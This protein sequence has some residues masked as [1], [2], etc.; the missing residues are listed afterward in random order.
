MTAQRRS[1]GIGVALVALLVSRAVTGV[2]TAALAPLV[3]VGVRANQVASTSTVLSHLAAFGV[4]ALVVNTLVA[5]WI[6]QAMVRM[7]GAGLSF[8]RALCGLLA[9]GLASALL[10]ALL[11]AGH[12]SAVGIAI[13]IFISLP[14]TI[15]VLVSGGGGRTGDDEPATA[16]YRRPPSAPAGWPGG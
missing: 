5:A 8:A 10:T 4:L 11:L 12:P 1:P 7:L 15:A 14:V 9:G 3:L 6:V 16:R 13:A 2:V